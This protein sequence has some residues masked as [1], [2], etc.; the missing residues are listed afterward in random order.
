LGVHRSDDVLLDEFGLS[1]QQ[2]ELPQHDDEGDEGAQP[3]DA[4]TNPV[5]H[6][7]PHGDGDRLLGGDERR[8]HVELIGKELVEAAAA[9]LLGREIKTD[10]EGSRIVW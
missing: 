10:I 5:D 4:G 9:E 7:Q 3:A 1:P 6:F 8:Q 2:V